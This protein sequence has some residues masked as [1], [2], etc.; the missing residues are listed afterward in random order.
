MSCAK[1]VIR[2]GDYSGDCPTR[3]S[4]PQLDRIPRTLP[5]II[6]QIDD[7]EVLQ[8]EAGFAILDEITGDFIIDD[9]KA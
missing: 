9:L 5:P 2:S 3:P 8:D 6:R 4:L 7:P 1:P